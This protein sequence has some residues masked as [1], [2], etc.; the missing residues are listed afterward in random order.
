[1]DIKD[2]GNIKWQGF[3]MPEQVQMLKELEIDMERVKK[4]QLDEQGWE[5]INEVLHTA[6]EYRLP[7]VF[8]LWID[9]FF[10]E[11]EGILHYINEVKKMVHV[12]DI[13]ENVQMVKFDSI[14]GVEFSN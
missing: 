1:M 10:E 8:T 12:V 7:I 14:V 11:V 9:G 2:R 13:Y 4:P 5:Q 6:I 3:M